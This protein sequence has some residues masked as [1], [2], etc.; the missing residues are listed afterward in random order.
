MELFS[1]FLGIVFGILLTLGAIFVALF[2]V[3]TFGEVGGLRFSGAMLDSKIKA[4]L[5][6]DQITPLSTMVPIYPLLTK[7][8]GTK[9][10]SESHNPDVGISGGAKPTCVDTVIGDYYTKLLQ[11]VETA[12][13][14]DVG[15]SAVWFNVLI[16]TALR[17]VF[18]LTQFIEIEN[19]G[20]VKKIHPR[21]HSA[22]PENPEIL[23]CGEN[24]ESTV[25]LSLLNSLLSKA[26]LP[27]ALGPVVLSHLRL[28]HFYPVIHEAR[29]VHFSSPPHS[30]SA[31]S[32]SDEEVALPEREPVVM[33]IDFS[34][35]ADSAVELH[36]SLR[37]GAGP[38]PDLATLPIQAA[39]SG[40]FFGGRLRFALDFDV[41]SPSVALCFTE[42]PLVNL[43]VATAI[44]HSVQLV[45]IPHLHGALL[46]LIRTNLKQHMVAPQMLTFPILGEQIEQVK[47]FV[48]DLL[49]GTKT[50]GSGRGT[51][52]SPDSSALRKRR[53]EA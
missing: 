7:F 46:S 10:E 1:I 39:V 17:F 51:I 22:H 42:E 2:K 38:I 15:E 26:E 4:S 32:A 49:N 19:A 35:V 44:G 13:G 36:T 21:T 20:S 33:E 43:E 31:E 40:I 47:I 24:T 34:L 5:Q 53:V 52:S 9:A 50:G 11:K 45:N 27:P 48:S 25:L 16:M 23:P 18:D 29:V 41:K 12:Q 14:S 3:N 8:F 37:V 28:G 6:R 30:N